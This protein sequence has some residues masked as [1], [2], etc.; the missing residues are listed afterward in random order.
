MRR[1]GRL[2]MEYWREPLPGEW[3][4]GCAVLV[5]GILELIRHV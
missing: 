3:L 5:L 1:L 4:L 2:T